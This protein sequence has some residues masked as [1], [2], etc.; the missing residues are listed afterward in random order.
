MVLLA[1]WDF[2][3]DDGASGREIGLMQRRQ[4]LEDLRMGSVTGPR[5]LQGR[6]QM[7][8][9]QKGQDENERDEIAE[10]KKS[11]YKENLPDKDPLRHFDSSFKQVLHFPCVLKK[12]SFADFKLLL[13]LLRSRT[14]P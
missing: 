12:G 13:G 3:H 5:I 14:V 2:E 6:L 11:N 9:E 4:R 10:P 1:T 8:A 7:L